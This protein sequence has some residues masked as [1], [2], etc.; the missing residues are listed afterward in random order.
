MLFKKKIQIATFKSYFN[1]ATKY[2]DEREK[3][4][5]RGWKGD[6]KLSA[7]ECNNGL[8]SLTWLL[9]NSYIKGV[10]CY[11]IWKSQHTAIPDADL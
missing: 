2:K 10:Y 11:V 5:G 9:I 7:F 1:I 6:S 8:G 3:K 4:E